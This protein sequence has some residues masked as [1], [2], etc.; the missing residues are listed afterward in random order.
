M[1]RK[2]RKVF[3][4]EIA[5]SAV[6][7]NLKLPTAIYARLSVEN[8]GNETD[9]TLQNQLAIIETYVMEQDDLELVDTYVDNG[10][11]GTK[12]DR[13]DFNRLMS[14]VKKGKVKCIVVKDLSR[15]G[16]DYLEAGYY[17]ETVFP[18]LNIRFISINDNFDSSRYED[19]NSL[20][21]PVKNMVN[22]MYSK[23]FSHKIGVSV[24]QAKSDRR[25]MG[26]CEAY[27][28]KFDKESG[29]LVIDREVESVVRLIFSWR[30]SG[31]SVTKIADRL[32]DINIP[33]PGEYYGWAKD[34]KWH[35]GTISRIIRNPVYG[36]YHVMNKS[37][38]SLYD[39]VKFHNNDESEWIFTPNS[40]EPYLLPSEYEFIHNNR[41]KSDENRKASLIKREQERDN[42]QNVFNG[43]VY[44]SK[45]GRKL[46]FSRKNR[47]WG[48]KYSH[49]IYHHSFDIKPG[50][51]LPIRIQLNQVKVAVIDRINELIDSSAIIAHKTNEILK[52]KPINNQ[53]ASLERKRSRL[54][55]Q[56]SIY[57]DKAS[58]AYA[59]YVE[60]KISSQEYGLIKRRLDMDKRQAESQFTEVEIQ[61]ADIN[62]KLKSLEKFSDEYSNEG[63]ITEITPSLANRMIEKILVDDKGSVE[64]VFKD[65]N[66]SDVNLI[67]ELVGIEEA[68]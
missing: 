28:Y 7:P 43:L 41:H 50:E 32:N 21:I 3:N 23:D 64:V 57:K 11:T 1:A 12:F 6:K 38:K 53:V 52:N 19:R 25:V 9:E 18:L 31:L 8:G 36:G 4:P 62:S 60:Q 59:D 44:C 13:P 14:D 39:G 51:C 37:H 63:M 67:K 10:F 15:F 26:N 68:E 34:S 24:E 2:S 55:E 49:A 58:D 30:L 33:S 61:I 16:R 47:D 54:E 45:C 56:I 35:S 17:L 65:I 5:N 42:L 40:H 29:R 48:S 46:N 27:G 22:A 20:S 66:F